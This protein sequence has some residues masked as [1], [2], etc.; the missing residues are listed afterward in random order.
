[1]CSSKSVGTSRAA[2]QGVNLWPAQAVKVIELHGRQRPA[3]LHHF[4]WWIIK[5]TAL[6]VGADDENPHVALVCGLD[7][8]PIEIIHEIP[9]EVHVIE[10]LAG[11]RLVDDIGRG[12][13]GEAEEANTTFALELPRGR[14]T[15][16]LL[17]RPSKQ[18]ALV[19]AVQCEQID[20]VEPEIVHGLVKSLQELVRVL[21][22]RDLGLDNDLVARDGWQ[23]SAR[24]A[25]R[26]NRSHELFR[27]G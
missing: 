27:C 22:R 5:F 4:G 18:F 13:G 26:K 24:V 2:T 1:M 21:K 16:V 7:A 8:G 19:D 3:K 6:V 25:S 20:V 17:Q 10:L 12:V 23:K 9:M 11:N 15:T 14:H